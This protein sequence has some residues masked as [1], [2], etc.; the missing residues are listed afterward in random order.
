MFYSIYSYIDTFEP[1]EQVTLHTCV[2]IVQINWSDY[3]HIDNNPYI[4]MKHYNDTD[5]FEQHQW[6]QHIPKCN[7]TNS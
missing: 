6:R 1:R 5:I 2:E 3:V 4:W 7:G